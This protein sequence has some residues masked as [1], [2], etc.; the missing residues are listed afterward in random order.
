VVGL[1]LNTGEQLNALLCA[2]EEQENA[3]AS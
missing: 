3:Q 1:R 2:I